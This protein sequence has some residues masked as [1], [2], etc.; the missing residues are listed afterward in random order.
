MTKLFHIK[1]HVNNTNIDALF[2]LRSQENF[3]AI[4]MVNTL[5]M[6]RSLDG[7]GGGR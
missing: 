4:G 1:I 3:I 5:R 7:Q 6:W 2:D